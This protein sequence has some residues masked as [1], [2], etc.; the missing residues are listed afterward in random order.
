[1]LVHH[2]GHQGENGRGSSAVLGA[3]NTELRVTK[4]KGVVTVHTDKQKD[5]AE[6]QPT[7]FDLE[8]EGDS[9]VLV[10]G[11]PFDAATAV[12]AES[13]AAD[14]MLKLL[15]ETAPRLG[16]TKGEAKRTVSQSDKDKFGKA[17]SDKTFLRSWDRAVVS[18][19]LA[20]VVDADGRTTARF[21]VTE[22]V[23]R[24]FGL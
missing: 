18:G 4:D 20:Q 13:P 9:A 5:E 7:Q 2:L 12:G 6:A 17:M 15:Y 10:G 11:D 8:P 21:V 22:E 1:M 24:R 23:V 14:R 19:W 16:L 3:V